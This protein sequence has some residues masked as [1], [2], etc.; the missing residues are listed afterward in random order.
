MW[1]QDPKGAF[2]ISIYSRRKEA[3]I[4]D[5]CNITKAP[6]SN[7]N[8]VNDKFF[9][10]LFIQHKP[11]KSLIANSSDTLANVILSLIFK[12]SEI[13]LNESSSP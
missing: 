13:S 1:N 9:N 5:C 7:Y 11:S 10:A 3:F 6:L 2:Y 8:K 12:G 4:L